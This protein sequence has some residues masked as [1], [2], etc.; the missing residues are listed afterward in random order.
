MHRLLAGSV[1]VSDHAP[2]GTKLAVTIVRA[3]GNCKYILESEKCILFQQ[4]SQCGQSRVRKERSSTAHIILLNQYLPDY[5]KYQPP[6]R[7]CVT[8]NPTSSLFICKA[9]LKKK[10]Q[11]K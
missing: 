10:R 11:E 6:K 4:V 8:E 7:C 3:R 9:E 5:V 2:K 1:H